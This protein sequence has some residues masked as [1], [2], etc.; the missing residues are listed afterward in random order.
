MTNTDN[1]VKNIFLGVMIIS[2]GCMLYISLTDTIFS[3]TNVL[4][5][6]FLIFWLFFAMYRALMSS[7]KLNKETVANPIPEEGRRIRLTWLKHCRNV[8]SDVPNPYIGMIGYVRN[9]KTDGSFDLQCENCWLIVINE[10]KFEYL[11]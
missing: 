1:F 8:S 6:F 9:L 11:D 10:Y 7:I 4:C 3:K 5:A 2:V